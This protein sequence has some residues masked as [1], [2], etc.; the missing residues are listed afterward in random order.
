M[1][2]LYWQGVAR[3][4]TLKLLRSA[5]GRRQI[6][7]EEIIEL[8][9][10]LIQAKPDQAVGIGRSGVLKALLETLWPAPNNRHYRLIPHVKSFLVLEKIAETP[11]SGFDKPL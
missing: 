3:P 6:H 5:Q 7:G 9:R 2:E 8:V 11:V 10:I 1:T 4:R